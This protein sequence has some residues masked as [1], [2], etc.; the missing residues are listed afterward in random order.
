MRRLSHGEAFVRR[1]H[2]QLIEGAMKMSSIDRCRVALLLVAMA[3]CEAT[4]RGQG[5]DVVSR[6]APTRD[7][8]G[9]I[10]K[11]NYYLFGN[12]PTG[13]NIT[14]EELAQ[15]AGLEHLQELRMVRCPVT[16]KGLVHLKALRSLKLLSLA[17]TKV[18]DAGMKELQS[19]L[20][21]VVII[22]P[23][24]PGQAERVAQI[25]RLG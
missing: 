15:L 1:G 10:V 3:A 20:P 17:G 5:S 4:A 14:D 23:Q 13:T 6:G 16:D 12:I 8:Q 7:E 2:R 25:E 24:P 18:T 22:P 9:R 21:G 11:L 19:A